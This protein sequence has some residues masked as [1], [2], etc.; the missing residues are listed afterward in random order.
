[1]IGRKETPLNLNWYRNAHYRLLAESKRR[2]APISQP[3]KL[4]LMEACRVDYTLN[5]PTGRRTDAMNWLSVVD[6]YF[7][8][9]LVKAGVITDDSADIYQAG[10]WT[11]THNKSQPQ[12]VLARVTAVKWLLKK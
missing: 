11:V 6:K 5:L 10:S 9:W 3:D 1:M 8:D 7:L 4:G 2:F 12:Q